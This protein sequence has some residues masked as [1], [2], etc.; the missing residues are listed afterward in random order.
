MEGATTAGIGSTLQI[1]DYTQGS[2]SLIANDYTAND[3]AVLLPVEP[4]YLKPEKEE[5]HPRW[6]GETP[7]V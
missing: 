2:P 6:E 5:G 4:E 1:S 3:L 7:Q